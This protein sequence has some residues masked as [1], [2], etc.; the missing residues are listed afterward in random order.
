MGIVMLVYENFGTACVNIQNNQGDTQIA[1]AACRGKF[2]TVCYLL[3]LRAN[4]EIA[5]HSGNLPINLLTKHRDFVTLYGWDY[6]YFKLQAWHH[7][8]HRKYPSTFK[9]KAWATIISLSNLRSVIFLIMEAWDALIRNANN[10][11][12]VTVHPSL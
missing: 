3:K 11:T 8:I 12:R 1:N 7:R 5:N 2:S 9:A 4:P 10:E 6:L